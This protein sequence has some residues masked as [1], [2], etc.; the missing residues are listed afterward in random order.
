MTKANP[1]EI[2]NC[3]FFVGRIEWYASKKENFDDCCEYRNIISRG[4]ECDVMLRL[5]RLGIDASFVEGAES[6]EVYRFD[7][8]LSRYRLH[9]KVEIPKKWVCDPVDPE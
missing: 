3:E 2:Y 6:G 9:R 1:L 4:I 8:D 7:E 5:Q